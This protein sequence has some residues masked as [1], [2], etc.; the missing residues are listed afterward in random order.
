MFPVN[1]IYGKSINPNVDVWY[2]HIIEYRDVGDKNPKRI[3]KLKV[4]KSL[5]NKYKVCLLIFRTS[6]LRK[7]FV[8]F[9]ILFIN[10][11]PADTPLIDL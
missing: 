8:S 3:I 11:F 10:Q 1:T 6:V 7:T 5:R 9:K 4:K 2:Q